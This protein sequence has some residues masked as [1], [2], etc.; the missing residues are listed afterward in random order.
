MKKGIPLLNHTD[1]SL[2]PMVGFKKRNSFSSTLAKPWPCPTNKRN[3]VS[4]STH[5]ILLP[6]F[7]LYQ[8]SQYISRDFLP[9]ISR[10]Y[11]IKKNTNSIREDFESHETLE[12]TVRGMVISITGSLD[13]H[14]G[15][16]LT[17]VAVTVPELEI[18]L[19]VVACENRGTC[20]QKVIFVL[21]FV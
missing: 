18:K 8:L 3:Q 11:H 9:Y 14:S 12:V 2:L 10:L 5:G 6:D 19:S 13:P 21:S 7:R 1:I 16:Q 4:R 15:L 17:N 20:Q